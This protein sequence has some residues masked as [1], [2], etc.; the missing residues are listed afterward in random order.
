MSTQAELLAL[1]VLHA[2]LHAGTSLIRG[3]RLVPLQSSVPASCLILRTPFSLDVALEVIVS[4]LCRLRNIRNLLCCSLEGSRPA[5]SGWLAGWGQLTGLRIGAEWQGPLKIRLVLG[6]S[7]QSPDPRSHQTQH[8]GV[9]CLA[10][11]FCQ[12]EGPG[13]T[14]IVRP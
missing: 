10:L 8:L 2:S 3:F 7:Q 4:F 11:L 6:D 12:G 9:I 5:A 13:Q 1:S 14:L